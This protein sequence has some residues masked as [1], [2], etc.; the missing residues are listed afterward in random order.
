MF[1]CRTLDGGVRVL[2]KDYSIRCSTDRHAAFELIAGAYVICVSL[3]IPLYVRCASQ[4]V[5]VAAAIDASN[6]HSS[7]FRWYC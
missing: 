7:A 2:I 6:G 1:N 3:G 5:R 4:L